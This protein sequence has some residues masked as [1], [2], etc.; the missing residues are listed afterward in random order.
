VTWRSSLPSLARRRLAGLLAAT[1]L[2]LSVG[3]GAF[4]VWRVRA[5]EVP[6]TSGGSPAPGVGAFHVHSD[7][8]PDSS[9]SIPAITAAAQLDHLAF[10]ILADHN[11]Q[12]AGPV[13]RD[14]VVLLSWAEL[15]TVFGHVVGL[16]SRGVLGREARASGSVLQ[17]VRALGAAPIV[18]HPG[19]PKQPWGGPW[20]D[21]AGLEVANF[22]SSTRRAGG[23]A[24]LGLAPILAASVLN[25]RLALAQLYDRDPQALADWDRNPDPA[26]VGL[27]GVDAHGWLD[28]ARS[29]L[30]WTVVLDGPLPDAEAARPAWV[31]RQLTQARFY[32]SAG[33]LGE[34]PGLTLE[35]HREDDHRVARAGESLPVAGVRELVA[36]VDV[37]RRG[38][39]LVLFRNGLAI[40]R[41]EGRE[42]RLD[43][44]TAGSYRVELWVTVPDLVTGDHVV[45]A[46]YSQRLRLTPEPVPTADPAGGP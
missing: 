31:V 2:V 21:A 40:D 7:M 23:H 5:R 35:A 17:R 25:P 45:A 1:A 3:A 24:F 43:S 19:D 32:C 28:L 26:F 20:H 41:S 10:V 29:L 9:T 11:A 33:L 36:R 34:P 38:Q 16:G 46:A 42:L 37:S 13:V 18:T 15:S 22:L 30:A 39:A 27:C 44:P 12:Y 6:H 8:S 4:V 14:G